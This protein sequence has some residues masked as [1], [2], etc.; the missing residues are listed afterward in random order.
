MNHLAHAAA[1]LAAAGDNFRRLLAWLRL[2]LRL[3][4]SAL[5]ESGGSQNAPAAA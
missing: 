4:I 1:V 2:L 3:W 5:I